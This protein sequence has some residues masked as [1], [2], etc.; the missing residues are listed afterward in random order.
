MSVEEQDVETIQPFNH[1]V[2]KFIFSCKFIFFMNAVFERLR[3]ELSGFLY[4]FYQFY[5]SKL[6]SLYV[7]IFNFYRNKDINNQVSV[8][9]SGK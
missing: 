9:D 6:H 1:S 8:H 3:H 2:S 4:A 7:V 5:M